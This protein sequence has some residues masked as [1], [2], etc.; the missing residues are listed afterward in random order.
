[1]E[2]I[3][4]RAELARLAD[5]DPWVRWVVPE[6][7]PAQI[8]FDGH[9][10]VIQRDGK[11][12]G[13]WVTPLD[14]PDVPADRL[15]AALT[16]LVAS[17]LLDEPDIVAVSAPQSHAALLESLLGLGEGGDWEW[18]WTT[19]PP[20][21]DP[22]EADIV[23]LDDRADGSEIEAFSRRNNPRVWTEIGTGRMHGWLGLRD[24]AGALIAVGGAEREAT[25]VPHLAGIVT[26]EDRRRE[27]LG[28]V[29]SAALTRRA[30]AEH[31]VC[32]L[33]MFSDNDT[34]RRVYHRLGYRTAR[35]W[36]SRRLP[37]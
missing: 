4:S 14:R 34:A 22:R 3:T 36:A 16:W 21:T 26:A 35:A 23:E 20:A 13:L 24:A 18:M 5:G 10:A 17:G 31:G 9:V 7:L 25:G 2:R 19:T 1:M 8:W 37:R 15:R 27:G 11:R 32:T 29:I 28:S 12:P 30:I 6:Q 33:G